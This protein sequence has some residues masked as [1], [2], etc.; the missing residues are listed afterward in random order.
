MLIASNIGCIFPLDQPPWKPFSQEEIHEHVHVAA[1][2]MN[3]IAE[4]DAWGVHRRWRTASRLFGLSL[5]LSVASGSMEM[6]EHYL[7]YDH[8][9]YRGHLI[10]QAASMGR[11]DMVRFIHDY[12]IESSPWCFKLEPHWSQDKLDLNKA[13]RSPNPAVWDYIMEQVD[14]H[15]RSYAIRRFKWHLK[16][17]ARRGWTD[18]ARHL[19]EKYGPHPKRSL[20]AEE[21]H[22]ISHAEQNGIHRFENP[23]FREHSSAM[24][25]A[26]R[27]G[28]LEFVQM[29][30]ENGCG[31]EGAVVAAAKHGQGDIVKVLLENGA[32]P[33]DA[34]IDLPAI[35]YAVLTEHTSMFYCLIEHGAGFPS[36]AMRENCASRPNQ[37]G[38][39][40]MLAL[41]DSWDLAPICAEA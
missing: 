33:N 29:L 11:L 37:T 4:V 24:R 16:N 17:C 28:N 27:L 2:Y 3:H 15:G 40:S 39:D 22:A 18:M 8:I 34:N 13:L 41:L 12:E 21:Q 5:D 14:D 25:S 23:S 9:C 26:A 32:D 35:C 1:V 19:V 30:L 10:R 7:R 38:V 31:V 6:V 20:S 36:S